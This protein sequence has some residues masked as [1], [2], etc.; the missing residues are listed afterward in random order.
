M[1]AARDGKRIKEAMDRA[2]ALEPGMD[3]AYFGLGM[4]KH[5]ADVARRRRE[6][7]AS[8]CSAGRDRKE[9]LREMLRAA[10]GA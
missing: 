4:H 10:A 5:Y 9:G 7:C 3:D 8:C 6:S 2:V 1:S